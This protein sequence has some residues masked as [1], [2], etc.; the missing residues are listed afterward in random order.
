M[1]GENN[2]CAKFYRIVAQNGNKLP[3]MQRFAAAQQKE[4][5]LALCIYGYFN[6][7][8]LGQTQRE[9][10]AIFLHS[11]IMEAAM[12][13]IELGKFD[14]LETCFSLGWLTAEMLDGLIRTAMICRKT[15]ILVW[16]LQLKS[17]LVGYIDRDFSF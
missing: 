9:V 17:K 6:A 3:L 7:K 4:M 12:T 14:E 16:L 15:E 11:H 13:L 5:K 1:N 2:N 10:L 8:M